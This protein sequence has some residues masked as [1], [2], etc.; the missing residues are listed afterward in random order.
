MKFNG[1]KLAQE[2]LEELKPQVKK[3]R[4]K[5]I[6]PHLAIILIGNDPASKKYVEQKI[7]K[8]KEVGVK[9]TLFTFEKTNEDQLKTLVD[10]LN[11]NELIHGIIIQ[12]PLPEEINERFAR[13]IVSKEKDVDGF[14][15]DSE[16][17][18]PIADAVLEILKTIFSSFSRSDLVKDG[19]FIH[20]LKEK[21]NV[22]VG[23]G[24]TGGRPIISMYRKLGVEPLII[25]SKTKNPAELVG[26]A[27][28]LIS[29]VGKPVI[30][31]E[32]VKKEAVVIGIG[33]HKGKDGKLKPDYNEEEISK[34]ASYY[35]PVPGGVGP[36]NVAML[37]KN[38]ACS[39][40]VK[41]K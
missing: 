20:W 34:I 18:E 10:K 33:M 40:S 27:D 19:A 31:S 9:T 21:T 6:I 17:N 23:K 29:T 13:S 12:R 32:E 38:V 37:L 16:F 22:V 5:R 36:V 39:S 15:P 30:R 25:D 41:N 24:D 4:E 28:I 2:I 1:E 35:T 11:K 14:R 8:A 26:K 7:K 3:L